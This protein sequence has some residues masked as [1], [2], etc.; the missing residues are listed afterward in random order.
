MAANDIVR[1]GLIMLIMIIR[2]REHAMMF[3]FNI[4]LHKLE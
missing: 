2:L 3:I 4:V 1:V